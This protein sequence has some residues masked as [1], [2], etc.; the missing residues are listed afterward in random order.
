MSTAACTVSYNQVAAEEQI[1]LSGY[2]NYT[3]SPASNS[4]LRNACNGTYMLFITNKILDRQ[5]IHNCMCIWLLN[6]QEG[7]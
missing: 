5:Y 3:C 6:V 4:K 7:R 1:S 2:K